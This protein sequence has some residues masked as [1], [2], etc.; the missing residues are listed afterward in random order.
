MTVS[1]AGLLI[2]G[3]GNFVV[4]NEG[5]LVL[6]TSDGPLLNPAINFPQ[7][8]DATNITI[9]G[10]GRVT[11]DVD[12]TVQEL[13]TIELVTFPNPHGLSLEGGNLYTET[14]ASGSPITG[15]PGDQGFGTIVQRYLE[16]SNV[17]SV[18]E[19]VGMIRTQRSFEMNSQSIRA[20]D[21]NMKV[22]SN[23]RR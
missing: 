3:R 16:A 2:L 4:N 18:R 8:V 17:D 12:G 1:A 9:L 13:G 7:G 11:A 10:D 20:V 23:L 21:E 15:N 14:L 22:V 5:N 19:L 6:G